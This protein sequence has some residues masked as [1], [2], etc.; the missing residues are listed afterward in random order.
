M[1]RPYNF[2]FPSPYAYTPPRW[3]ANR[4]S[5]RLNSSHLVIS[6]DVFISAAL[7][8]VWPPRAEHTQRVGSR[9]R[10]PLVAVCASLFFPPVQ[11]TGD[12]SALPPSYFPLPAPTPY[13]PQR[14]STHIIGD[15]LFPDDVV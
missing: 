8:T 12:P 1:L 2:S 15:S 4:K 3:C 11:P 5:T 7:V 9:C 13:P 10:N 14:W 6:Y